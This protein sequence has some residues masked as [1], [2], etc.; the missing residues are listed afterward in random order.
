MKLLITKNELASL[1]SRERVLLECEFCHIHFTK[2]K[3]EVLWAISRT[4]TQACRFCSPACFGQ[5][6]RKR[7]EV[8]CD[9][10]G[11]SFS[12]TNQRVSK[13]NFC[14]KSCSAKYNNKCK[15]HGARR[16]KIE[17]YVENILK[18]NFPH[19]DIMPNDRSLG[20]ELDLF[21]PGLKFAIE[22]NGPV[23]YEPIYGTDKF[24]AIQSKDKHKTTLCRDNGIELCVIDISQIKYWKQSRL[25]EYAT[26]IQHIIEPLLSRLE[27]RVWDSNP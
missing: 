12:K 11:K 17:I 13:H 23:H 3:H 7:T 24:E 18:T 8:V 26:M 15:K 16:S 10:C 21:F 25:D 2:P 1:K 19:L 14:N 5:A 4:D 20:L 9:E 27:R 22:F 6:T